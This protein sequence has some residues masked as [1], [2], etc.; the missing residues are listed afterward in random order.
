[1]KTLEVVTSF[2]YRPT[3]PGQGIKITALSRNTNTGEQEEQVLYVQTHC[4]NSDKYF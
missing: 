4:H 1:V 2:N 3:K